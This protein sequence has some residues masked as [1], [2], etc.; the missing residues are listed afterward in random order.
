LTD[1]FPARVSFVK[2]VFVGIY[3]F[4]DLT[5]SRG[6]STVDEHVLPLDQA[7]WLLESPY[8]V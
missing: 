6:L 3:H 4:T 5:G 8:C 1:K 2:H 7:T